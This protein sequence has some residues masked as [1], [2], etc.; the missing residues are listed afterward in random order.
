MLI[1]IWKNIKNTGVKLWKKKHFF[2]G[3][4]YSKKLIYLCCVMTN[5]SFFSW[6]ESGL[7]CVNLQFY[8]WLNDGNVF[9]SCRARRLIWDTACFPLKFDLVHKANYKCFDNFPFENFFIHMEHASDQ[10]ITEHYIFTNK[11]RYLLIIKSQ[12]LVHLMLY[13]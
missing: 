8:S 4:H 12:F 11:K 6:N 3:V 7:N 9:R 5:L 13:T 2:S 10:Q 1:Y